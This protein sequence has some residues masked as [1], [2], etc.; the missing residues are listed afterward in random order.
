MSEAPIPVVDP[1]AF[2]QQLI[3]RGF[4]DQNRQYWWPLLPFLRLHGQ[5]RLRESSYAS[6]M[7]TYRARYLQARIAYTLHH[8][9]STLSKTAQTLT[10]LLSEDQGG[11][12]LQ[13]Q[14]AVVTKLIGHFYRLSSQEG[15]I[16]V[17]PLI[18]LLVE[19]LR[20]RLDTVFCMLVDLMGGSADYNL[21]RTFSEH[22]LQLDLLRRVIQS[23][24][25]RTYAALR[26]IDAVSN[27]HLSHFT[28]NFFATILPEHAARC[29]LDV[30][31]LE[32]EV[33]LFRGCVGF[34]SIY[35][36]E[37]K[38]KLVGT[39]ARGKRLTAKD[40]WSFLATEEGRQSSVGGVSFWWSRLPTK[41]CL[42]VTRNRLATLRKKTDEG[43]GWL[44]FSSWC[45]GAQDFAEPGS[46]T[47]TEAFRSGFA[48]NH[49]SSEKHDSPGVCTLSSR[50]E[51][52]DATPT[53]ENLFV[54]PG[55]GV[56]TGDP[57][58]PAPPPSTKR[59]STVVGS[60]WASNHGCDTDLL[61]ARLH[62]D[63]QV[64]GQALS[65]IYDTGQCVQAAPQ[66]AIFLGI[67]SW[68]VKS[69]LGT[70]T[71]AR[72]CAVGNGVG[73]IGAGPA[74]FL[75]GRTSGAQLLR[76]RSRGGH[77]R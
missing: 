49:L 5:E 67:E 46:G 39:G 63:S 16:L 64:H 2:L 12:S 24:M 42:G 35:K 9:E 50:E 8:P 44:F 32:G 65:T 68:F 30:F 15:L 41:V 75:L 76:R 40:V 71:G 62:V 17:T 70:E 66:S 33:A 51:D 10:E 45:I 58:G 77:D 22:S 14:T 72:S 37:I 6:I 18:N 53:R 74:A 1:E 11:M 13:Q 4:S 54:A 43:F 34:L 3:H 61:A 60:D 57:D 26:S 7:R 25:P 31:L 47:E 55:S 52:T 27:D 38:E 21:P 69:P 20:P 36:K 23:V 19:V 59:G 29:L 48:C 73:V 28:I 56:G